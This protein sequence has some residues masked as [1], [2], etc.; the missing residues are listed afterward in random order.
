MTRFEKVRSLI[1]SFFFSEESDAWLG[2]LRIGL[3]VVVVCYVLSLANV[4]NLLF[5]T[6][7]PALVTRDLSEALLSLQSRFVPR[8]GWLVDAGQRF[9][10]KEQVVLQFVWICLLA[11]GLSLILGIFSR[12]TA[13]LAWFLHLCAARSGS[14][15]SYGVDDFMT[16]GLFYLMLSPL[17]DRFA[18]DRR[19]RRLKPRKSATSGVF[20][21]VLQLHLSLIYFFSGLTKCLGV[22]W[23]NGE[24]LWRALTRPPF[25]V[26]SAD[27]LVRFKI[28]FPVIGIVICLLETSYPIFIWWRRSR[29]VLLAAIL[30]MHA[31]IGLLMGMY[32]FAMVMIVLNLAAFGAALVPGR[33]QK[34]NYGSEKAVLVLDGPAPE[35]HEPRGR[36]RS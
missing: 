3:G 14:F 34:F 17:P 18:F 31:A 22:G 21:R 13:V 19:T 30:A 29:A 32:L 4:W 15:V 5:A 7:G 10:L 27:I 12:F 24:N 23:W 9:G 16:I 36:N 6:T 26:V 25:D 1:A 11:S 28:L 8:I 35:T 33:A 20:H 2:I